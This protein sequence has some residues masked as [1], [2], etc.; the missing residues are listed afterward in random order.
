MPLTAL[1]SIVSDHGE[2][3]ET[4][5]EASTPMQL[6]VL[7]AHHFMAVGESDWS[8]LRIDAVNASRSLD[9]MTLRRSRPFRE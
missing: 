1:C 9:D 4:L 8:E 7:L 5:I 2:T 6:F 3:V